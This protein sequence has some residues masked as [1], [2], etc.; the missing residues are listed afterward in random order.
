MELIFDVLLTE[1]QTKFASFSRF[2]IVG[3]TYGDS[4][5]RFTDLYAYD[6]NTSLNVRRCFAIQSLGIVDF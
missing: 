3:E 6:L 2:V 1:E 4:A 5:K